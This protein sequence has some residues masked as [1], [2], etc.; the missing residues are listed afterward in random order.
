MNAARNPRGEARRRHRARRVCR[1]CGTNYTA[2]GVTPSP[3]ICEVC[4]GDV[5]QHADSTPDSV[6]RRL[7][8]YEEQT[9]P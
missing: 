1:D 9:F 4:G 2:S 5:K 8:L 7:D 3:W 6:N